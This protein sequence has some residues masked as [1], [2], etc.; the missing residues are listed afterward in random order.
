[1]GQSTVVSIDR[2]SLCTGGPCVQVVLVYRW[3]LC[4]GSACTQVVLM[5]RWSLCAGGPCVWVVLVYR[6]SLCR[7]GPC[8]WVVLVYRWSLCTGGPCVQVVLVYRWSLCTGGFCIQVDVKTG[9]N[10]LLLF[11]F[12]FIFF[13]FQGREDVVPV[14]DSTMDIL[15]GKGSPSTA[16]HIE[17]I[18]R[19]ANGKSTTLYSK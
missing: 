10:I 6:W 5:Y 7:G 9:F 13:A 1:M 8:V 11:P 16:H 15:K 19:K 18:I 12:I 17:K 2:W 14:V 4:T 3:S